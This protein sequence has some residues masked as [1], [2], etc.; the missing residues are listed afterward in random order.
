MSTMKEVCDKVGISYET[1]RYYCNEGLVP[2]VKRDRNNYRDF[3]EKN[4]NWLMGLQHLRK[5]GM[6]IKDMKIYMELCIQG[7]STIPERKQMLHNLKIGLLQKQAVLDEC[8]DFIDGKQIFY[9][10][11]MS[12]KVEYVSNLTY[13]G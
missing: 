11:V 2:N 7:K 5:C 12:G 8:V 4:I 1:L 9:D 10:D 13:D 6:S 3:N